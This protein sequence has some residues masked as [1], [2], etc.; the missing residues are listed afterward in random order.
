MVV[1]DWLTMM[2]VPIICIK[3]ISHLIARVST[4]MSMGGDRE[5]ISS[6]LDLIHSSRV[7]RKVMRLAG[8][9]RASNA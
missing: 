9:N 3:I 8:E 1:F 7:I 5:T 2:I 4:F 6:L